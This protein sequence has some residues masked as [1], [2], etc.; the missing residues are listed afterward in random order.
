MHLH[1][2]RDKIESKESK[3]AVIGLGYVG[4]PVACAFAEA[5]FN[6]VGV[7][8]QEERVAK[9]NAGVSPIEGDEP[10]LADLV[11]SVAC[12]GRFHATT[13]YGLLQRPGCDL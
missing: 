9:I 12:S 4:L 3:L 1:E 13:D 8:R 6:V 10:G 2:L 7:E 5:G 11:R